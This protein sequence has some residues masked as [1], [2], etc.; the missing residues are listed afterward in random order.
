LLSNTEI[1]SKHSAGENFSVQ[2]IKP[3]L[4]QVPSSIIQKAKP[5]GVNN[6]KILTGTIFT[7]VFRLGLNLYQL[8]C[9]LVKAAKDR[10]LNFV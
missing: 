6:S 7:Y 8:E 2:I 5:N 1:K 10:V 4:F 9:N 3:V